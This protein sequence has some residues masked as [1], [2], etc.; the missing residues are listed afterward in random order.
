[1]A[2]WD[3]LRRV[4]WA[5]VRVGAGDLLR[6]RPKAVETRTPDAT[7]PA[8]FVA[9]LSAY[10]KTDR[11]GHTYMYHFRSDAHSVELCYLI[12]EDLVAACPLVRTHALA[13]KVAYGINVE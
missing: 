7:A 9:W 2:G 10:Q 1:V 12:L 3:P 6:T 13:D 8:R 5:A 11:H 4:K